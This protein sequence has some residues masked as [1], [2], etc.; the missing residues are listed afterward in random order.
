MEIQNEEISNTKATQQVIFLE[1]W[2]PYIQFSINNLFMKWQNRSA[3]ECPMGTSNT[4]ILTSF[5]F[6]T[7]IRE[8]KSFNAT[9]MECDAKS[10]N[11]SLCK[12][13]LLAQKKATFIVDSDKKPKDEL[14]LQDSK[15]SNSDCK[16]HDLNLTNCVT[17]TSS[18]SFI[19]I[20]VIIWILIIPVF[21]LVICQSFILANLDKEAQKTNWL[22]SKNGWF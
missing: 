20:S 11:I 5:V 7:I 2:S 18:L 3:F 16:A 21:A 8:K 12:T 19:I 10:F 13:D 14:C 1:V 9:C 17:K 4:G 15:I 22:L 6:S